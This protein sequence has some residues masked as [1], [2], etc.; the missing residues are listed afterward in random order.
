[1]MTAQERWGVESTSMTLGSKVDQ[2]AKSSDA[3]A[4]MLE[5]IAT[6][7]IGWSVET[8]ILVEGT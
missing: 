3:L 2:Q 7:M 5:V 6:E 1:M 8:G 4:V